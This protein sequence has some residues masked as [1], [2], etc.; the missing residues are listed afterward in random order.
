[1]P[2]VAIETQGRASIKNLARALAG[3]SEGACDSLQRSR[4]RPNLFSEPHSFE[5]FGRIANLFWFVPPG[6]D[7]DREAFSGSRHGESLAD[8]RTRQEVRLQPG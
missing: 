6:L 7:Q 1:M 8:Q 4:L 5:L 2:P 3:D